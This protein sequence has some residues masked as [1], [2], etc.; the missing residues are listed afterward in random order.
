MRYVMPEVREGDGEWCCVGFCRMGWRQREGTKK[1]TPLRGVPFGNIVI[2][3]RHISP[4]QRRMSLRLATIM[5][6]SRMPN[7][8]YSA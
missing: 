1:G 3:C 5:R 4:T 2:Q 6:S 8:K 7:P